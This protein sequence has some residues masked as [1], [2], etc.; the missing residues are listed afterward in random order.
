[1]EETVKR[2]RFGLQ[3]MIAYAF[4]FQNE[5]GRSPMRDMTLAVCGVIAGGVFLA[6]YR[7]IWR[8]RD[9]PARPPAFRQHILSE[10]IWATIPILMLLAAALP[11]VMAVVSGSR[12]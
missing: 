10:L 2:C 6:M 1:M 4:S 7:A 12:H 9:D 3:Y 11:A 5:F 8:T